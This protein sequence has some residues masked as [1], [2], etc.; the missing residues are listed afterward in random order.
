MYKQHLVLYEKRYRCDNGRESAVGSGG[1][2]F[3]TWDISS[4]GRTNQESTHWCW[5]L[6]LVCLSK[7]FR[8]PTHASLSVQEIGSRY[9]YQMNCNFYRT[10]STWL[11]CCVKRCDDWSFNTAYTAFTTRLLNSPKN[12]CFRNRKYIQSRLPILLMNAKQRT[13]TL[14]RRHSIERARKLGSWQKG[15][16]AFLI[17]FVF[18]ITFYWKFLK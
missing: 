14:D 18:K 7:T 11:I 8:W 16:L 4:E 3:D 1:V 15:E 10:V 17:R 6:L 2:S 5:E 9:K 12:L 13:V